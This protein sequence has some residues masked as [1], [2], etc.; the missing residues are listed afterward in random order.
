[1]GDLLLFWGLFRP[2][3][4]D[5]AGRSAFF[6]AAEHRLFGWLQ[7]GEVLRPGANGSAVLRSHP[8]LRDHPHARDGWG[9][10]NTLY[11]ASDRLRLA[12]RAPDVPGWGVF[13][14]GRRLSAAG[15]VPSTWTV[16]TWL[17]P[18][19]EGTGLSF[20][21]RSERWDAGNGTLRC[22]ARGQEFVADIGQRDDA[23]DWLA[24][25]WTEDRR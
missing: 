19:R 15:C 14:Q 1:M 16:P 24:A 7:V 11:V 4:C 12:G 3:R 22:A 13:A 21:D 23:L 10:R 5:A 20:H 18:T 25:L 17:D 6:G 9:E 2:V 8:W